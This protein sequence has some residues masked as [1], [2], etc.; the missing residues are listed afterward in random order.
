MTAQT[1]PQTMFGD[2]PGM[3]DELLSLVLAGRKTATCA[4]LESYEREG[5]P[6]P[7]PGSREIVLDGKKNPRCILEHYEV[8]VKAFNDVDEDFAKDEGEGDLSL[9][10]WRR[11][12]EKFFRRLGVFKPDMP[13][14]CT[15]FRV[16]ETLAAQGGTR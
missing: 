3:A 10:Y 2:S 6:L 11:E 15:R 13:L 7:T 5:E 8:S 1:L 16:V 4:A 9:T 12:H 14:V